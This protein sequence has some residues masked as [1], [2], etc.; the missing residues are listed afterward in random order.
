MSGPGSFGGRACR[1]LRRRLM[2]EGLQGL[3]PSFRASSWIVARIRATPEWADFKAIR[4]VYRKCAERERFTGIK[5]QVDHVVPLQSDWVCGLHVA[6]NLR[7]IPAITNG[8]KSNK[9]CQW[10]GELFDVPE[11]LRIFL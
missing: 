8:Q 7:V 6:A 9:W 3:P 1:N 4:A 2:A 10:H 5:H 11:Q